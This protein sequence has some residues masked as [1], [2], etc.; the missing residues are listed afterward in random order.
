MVAILFQCHYVNLAVIQYFR[1]NWIEDFS[2]KNLLDLLKNT[3]IQFVDTPQ[4][5]HNVEFSSAKL[6]F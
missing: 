4:V 2:R 6:K 5:Y 1:P 3:I